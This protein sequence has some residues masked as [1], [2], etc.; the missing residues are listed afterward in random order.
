MQKQ[1]QNHQMAVIDDFLPHD[2][3]REVWR[4]LQNEDYRNVHQ[5]GIAPVYR[6]GDGNPLVGR[7]VYVASRSSI[8][9]DLVA[10][11]NTAVPGSRVYPTNLAVDCLIRQLL[12]QASDFVDLIG[13][14]YDDWLYLTATASI[15]PQGTGLSW[16][17][18]GSRYTGAYIYY[19]HDEWNVTWGGEFLVQDEAISQEQN[20]AL[21]KKSTLHQFDNRAENEQL[22][23]R[24]MGM[25]IMPKP[26][27]LLVVA[28]GN[29]HA[30]TQVNRSAGNRVRATV[31]GFFVRPSVEQE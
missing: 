29:P 17:R 20:E 5:D 11:L 30:V 31:G 13:R 28:G 21:R 22:L 16:H 24:G 9:D 6:I 27:R 2:E 8:R 7:P 23:A 4:Y 1:F 14:A 12:S 3:F 15:Y 25:Y 19:G 26:N 18:D 10:S